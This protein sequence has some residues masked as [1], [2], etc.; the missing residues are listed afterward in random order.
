MAPQLF[1]T[2]RRESQ[3]CQAWWVLKKPGLERSSERGKSVI[4]R[5]CSDSQ[6]TEPGRGTTVA[7]FPSSSP[8]PREIHQESTSH[9]T[10][11]PSWILFKN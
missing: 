8:V 9:P 2:M 4:G 3:H 7:C 10:S 5:Q 6:E 1:P 11:T